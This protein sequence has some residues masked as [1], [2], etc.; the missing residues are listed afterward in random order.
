MVRRVILTGM[1]LA[2]LATSCAPMS[3]V[4]SMSV[5]TRDPK[6]DG[7]IYKAVEGEVK[8]KDCLYWFLGIFMAGNPQPNHETVVARMLEQYDADALL[9]AELDNTMYGFPYLFMQ[10]C[11]RAKG[12]PARLTGGQR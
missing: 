11:A 1:A 6:A 4:A 3:G 10:M 7:K 12:R 5:L 8:D 2:M 9:D